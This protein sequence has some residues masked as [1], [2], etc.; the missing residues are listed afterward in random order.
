MPPPPPPPEGFEGVYKPPTPPPPPH[1]T[2]LSLPPPPPP[3]ET[4]AAPVSSRLWSLAKSAASVTA[5]AAATA[6]A[7]A[8]AADEKYELSARAKAKAAELGKSAG[9]FAGRKASEAGTAVARRVGAMTPEERQQWLEGAT[10]VVAVAAAFGGTKTRALAGVGAVAV[11]L[12]SKANNVAT[13]LPT[14]RA[15]QYAD[16]LVEEQ[17][18]GGGGGGAYSSSEVAEVLTLEVV[19]AVPGGQT[20]KVSVEGIGAFEVAVPQ[21]INVGETFSFEIDAPLSREELEPEAVPMGLPAT[22]EPLNVVPTAVPVGQVG[23]G[24]APAIAPIPMAVGISGSMPVPVV[25]GPVAMMPT[26]HQPP[27]QQQVQPQQQPQ[28][29]IQ[30]ARG[31]IEDAR[32]AAAAAGTLAR[33][34]DKM[35]VTPQQA[36]N[37]GAQGVKLA[38]EMGVTREQALNGLVG[39]ARL[40]GGASSAQG[41]A[42]R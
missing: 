36:L 38:N 15:A 25:G 17:P 13:S 9:S 4:E 20:M 34:L 24:G 8:K 10:S 12:G 31:N 33:E 40:F 14:D 32:A 27:P 42:R 2:T 21:G 23:G 18:G 41:S 28:S 5:S 37:A 39:A 3:P 26:M 7:K 29:L 1:E 35:G 6:A 11:N 19:A 22:P 30:Q 16:Y